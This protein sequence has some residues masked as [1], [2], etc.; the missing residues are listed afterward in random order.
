[1]GYNIRWHIPDEAVCIIYDGW[2]QGFELAD[3]LKGLAT[4]LEGI[5]FPIALLMDYSKAE[6]FDHSGTLVFKIPIPESLKDKVRFGI[7][8]A[9]RDLFKDQAEL[10]AS[11]TGWHVEHHYNWQDAMEHYTALLQNY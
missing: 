2:Y 8:I 5:P 10:L 6:S 4:F 9:S 7:F 1:M 3:S 11:A